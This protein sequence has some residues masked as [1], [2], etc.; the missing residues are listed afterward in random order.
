MRG[1]LKCSMN[2]CWRLGCS[3]GGGSGPDPNW[4]CVDDLDSPGVGES[5]SQYGGGKRRG[6][7]LI[8]L[9]VVDGSGIVVIWRGWV[10]GPADGE[11][12]V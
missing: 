1:T 4:R 7:V 3:G 9:G 2:G 10:W 8:P 5:E 12:E 6:I 11:A